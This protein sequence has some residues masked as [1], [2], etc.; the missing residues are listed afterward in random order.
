MKFLV[1]RSSLGA[2]SKR[3]PCKG[4]VRGPES[5]AWPG[6]YEWFI[7]LETV[8]ALM[9]F[10]ENNGGGLGLYSP[11]PGE[12]CPVIEIFDDDEEG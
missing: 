9:A 1:S 11:E 3:S 10:L 6:E 7:E 4:A 8:E 2:V 5:P 12:E